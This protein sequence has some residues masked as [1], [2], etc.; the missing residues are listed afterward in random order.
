MMVHN[1][2]SK[3]E[4]EMEMEM[5]AQM[6]ECEWFTYRAV[7]RPIPLVEP[8]MMKVRPAMEGE[9]G[10]AIRGGRCLVRALCRSVWEV[11]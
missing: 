10:R 2:N 1:C 11:I 9:E 4:M 6:R 8:V 3:K 5:G 7:S